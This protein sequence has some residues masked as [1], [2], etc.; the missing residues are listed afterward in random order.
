M[1]IWIRPLTQIFVTAW[2]ACVRLI[3][4][5]DQDVDEKKSHFMCTKMLWT[6]KGS[7]IHSLRCLKTTFITFRKKNRT[8]IFAAEQP[9]FS[10]TTTAHN[11]VM[12]FVRSSTNSR[13]AVLLDAIWNNRKIVSLTSLSGTKL[14]QLA[15]RMI[16]RRYLH[17]RWKAVRDVWLSQ[18][19]RESFLISS[20]W[21]SL[22]SRIHKWRGEDW[23]AGVPAVWLVDCLAETHV[24]LWHTAES[25]L[26][27]VMSLLQPAV[28]S[29][30]FCCFVTVSRVPGQLCPAG[31]VDQSFSSQSLVGKIVLNFILACGQWSWTWYLHQERGFAWIAR[32]IVVICLLRHAYRFQHFRFFQC[33]GIY[34]ITSS[35]GIVQYNLVNLLLLPLMAKGLKDTDAS[36]YSCVLRNW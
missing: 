24:Y 30:Y 28:W 13:R 36:T 19:S 26:F 25:C 6:Q 16:W 11:K 1:F 3:L 7:Q 5:A 14:R 22:H 32:V 17:G 18:L 10:L 27:N 21:P 23:L 31:F 34:Q 35:L 15:P 9:C 33:T 8:K 12:K 2:K 20:G 29:I 4:C